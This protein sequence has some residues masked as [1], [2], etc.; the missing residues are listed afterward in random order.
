[1][2]NK[3][4]QT[5][6][7]HYDLLTEAFD[8]FSVSTPKGFAGGSDFTLSHPEFGS[9]TFESKTSNTDI[10]DAGVMSTCSAGFIKSLSG[11]Y[12]ETQKD[13]I[14]NILVSNAPQIID[15]CQ[16]ANVS[17][18]TYSTTKDTY[19]DI[20]AAGKLI[21]I[22][23]KPIDG[24]I[25]ATLTRMGDSLP[26]AHYVVVGDLIYRT[27][28]DYRLDPLHLQELGVPALTEEDIKV[29]EIRTRRGGSRGTSKRVSVGIRLGYKFGSKLPETP[30]KLDG[31]LK[32]IISAQLRKH[33]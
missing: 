32:Q 19:E 2:T 5:E 17:C 23:A 13:A 15:H 20:K 8:S 30:L 27:S 14:Q 33:Y 9:L 25:E 11:F 10:Y 22:R 28:I 3:G 16:L 4:L 6:Q 31:G 24:L 7:I 18:T 21:N 29:F 26:K 1:M 12:S